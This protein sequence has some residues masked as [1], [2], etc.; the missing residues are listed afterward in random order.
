MQ[1]ERD[2]RLKKIVRVPV[3]QRYCKV[4]NVNDEWRFYWDG[5]VLLIAIWNSVVIPFVISF[6]PPWAEEGWYE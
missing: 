5:L 1:W 4:F 6:D 2:R 3:R